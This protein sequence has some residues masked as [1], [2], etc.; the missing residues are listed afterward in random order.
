[1]HSD[2]EFINAPGLTAV[3]LTAACAENEQTHEMEPTGPN[4]KDVHGL[5]DGQK[6]CDA[7]ALAIEAGLVG[8]LIFSGGYSEKDGTLGLEGIDS[9]ASVYEET[10]LGL[11]KQHDFDITTMPEPILEEDSVNTVD[12]LKELKKRGLIDEGTVV[13]TSGYHVLR[14]KALLKK[15]GINA[16]VWSADAILREL[17]PDTFVDTL[18]P[19]N[20]TPLAHHRLVKEKKGWTDLKNGKY[21]EKEQLLDKAA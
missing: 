18:A 1:M 11:L 17:S 3:V 12:S 19:G 8:K 20:A 10:T 21:D 5:L 4:H 7:A 16:S 13:I 14:V 6:R 9:A 2:S 15:H